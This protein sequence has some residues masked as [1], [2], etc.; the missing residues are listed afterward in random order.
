[1]IVMM[2]SLW[3]VVDLKFNTFYIL[4]IISYY[5]NL[6]FE[7]KKNFVFKNFF[8]LFLIKFYRIYT[9]KYI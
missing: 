2:L 1:M 8:I 9:K 4:I 6:I 5:F 3:E 7:K